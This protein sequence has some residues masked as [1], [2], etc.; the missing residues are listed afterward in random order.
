M[1]AHDFYLKYV[2][3]LSRNMLLSLQSWECPTHNQVVYVPR[4]WVTAVNG[5]F[6]ETSW[7]NSLFTGMEKSTQVTMGSIPNSNCSQNW[8]T[9]HV[10]LTHRRFILLCDNFLSRLSVAIITEVPV[11]MENAR[12]IW[13]PVGSILKPQVLIGRRSSGPTKELARWLAEPT[14]SAYI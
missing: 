6:E 9:H 3:K 11:R 4:G 7:R 2:G 10:S 5:L 14:S 13:P 8:R 12:I 1:S